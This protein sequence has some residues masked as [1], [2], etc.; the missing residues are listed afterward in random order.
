MSTGMWSHCTSGSGWPNQT[1]FSTRIDW[2][3]SDELAKRAKEEGYNP[4]IPA[5]SFYMKEYDFDEKDLQELYSL[6]QHIIVY[7]RYAE[8]EAFDQIK[9]VIDRLYNSRAESVKIK[10]GDDTKNEDNEEPI[11]EQ[12]EPV[13]FTI[14]EVPSY[15]ECGKITPAMAFNI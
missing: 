4:D 11:I 15:E 6:Y 2:R 14:D 1:K 8:A 12:T 9:E 5:S 3:K 7:G 13:E 10:G